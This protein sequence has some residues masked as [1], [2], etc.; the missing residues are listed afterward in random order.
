MDKIKTIINTND[1]LIYFIAG[2]IAFLF[3]LVVFFLFRCHFL[4]KRNSQL[5][6]ENIRLMEDNKIIK[7]VETMKSDFITTVA[8]QIRTPLTRIKWSIQTVMNGEAGKVT[9][10]QKNILQT[11]YQANQSMVNIIN[12]LLESAKAESTYLGYDFQDEFL[13]PVVSNVV[14]NFKPVANQKKINLEFLTSEKTLPAVKMDP[15]KI[16][17]ALENLLDNALTY[18][19]EG[20]KISVIVENFGDCARVSVKDTG[21]GIPKD[22]LDKMFTRFF[23]AKNAV[24]I[25]TEGS[26]LGLYI[27]KNIIMMHGGEIWVESKEK[28]GT[29]FYF[30]IP[31]LGE[32]PGRN[33]EEFI[34]NI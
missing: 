25:K 9:T 13:E 17:L 1:E 33:V 18:T 31:F 15:G 3:L 22:A 30:T 28:E 32:S 29:T 21:I 27:T 11:G 6:S 16:G 19:P 10:E 7:E 24:S 2:T 4:K 20:G 14:N 26:G 34:S 5:T 23:R 8:H 12:N